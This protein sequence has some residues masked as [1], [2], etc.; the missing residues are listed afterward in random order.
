MHTLSLLT[1]GRELSPFR[2]PAAA[3]IKS[4]LKAFTATFNLS[5]RFAGGPRPQPFVNI[6]GVLFRR[7]YMRL[8]R[9]SLYLGWE[10]LRR[11]EKCTAASYYLTAFELDLQKLPRSLPINLRLKV[12]LQPTVLTNK[13]KLKCAIKLCCFFLL[14]SCFAITSPFLQMKIQKIAL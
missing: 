9:Q 11:Y 1:P 12:S 10:R 6:V 3:T 13:D 4:N 2:A 5:L 14:K 8:C 7:R